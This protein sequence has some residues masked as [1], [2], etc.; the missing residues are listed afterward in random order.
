MLALV[1][2]AGA[3]APCLAH[4]QDSQGFDN[5]V[6]WDQKRLSFKTGEHPYWSQGTLLVPFRALAGK[7]GAKVGRSQSGSHVTLDFAINH[8]EFEQGHID[9]WMN[10]V[11]IP[12]KATSEDHGG[13]LFVP[14]RLFTQATNHRVSYNRQGGPQE[15]NPD[16]G[17]QGGGGGNG[18][19]NGGG[20]NGGGR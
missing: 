8:V 16:Q 12:L 20:G 17:D 1:V 9:F 3:L 14:I 11:R 19:G 2:A 6:F 5:R 13:I 7:V 15:P 4:A 18:G 10:D